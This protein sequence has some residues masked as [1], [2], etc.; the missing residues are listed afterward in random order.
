[1]KLA[2]RR[3]WRA[4][5]AGCLPLALLLPAVTGCLRIPAP[6][7]PE[8]PVALPEHWS[9]PAEVLAV[10]T[11][12][13]GERWWAELGSPELD[14]LIEEALAA[15]PSLP[16]AAARLEAASAR[17]R[18]AGAELSPQ[19]AAAL[20]ASR[21]RQ[22]FVGLPIPGAEDEVLTVLAT[23]FGAS[24]NL[25]W[26]ADLWGRLRAGR[27]AARAEVELAIE[28][29]RGARLSLAAQTAKAWL[30]TVEAVAQ[31]ALAEEVDASWQRTEELVEA[32]Y[33]RGLTDAVDLRLARSG[34][35]A[36]Q[37]LL[38]LR[39]RQLDAA[40]RQLEAILGRY[41]AAALEIASELPTPPQALPA[42]L[43]VE[44][45][46]RRPDLAAAERRLEAAG[47]RTRQARAAFFPQLR[48]TASG[49][50]LSREVGDLLDG[51]FA[52]WNLAAGILQPIFQGGRLRAGVELAE[53]GV[54]K[55]LATYALEILR[56]LTEVETALAAEVLLARRVAAL[57]RAAQ[58]A[59]AATES[60]EARYRAGLLPF[61]AV[62]EARRQADGVRSQLLEARRQAVTN[63]VDLYLALGG[64]VELP[65]GAS[66]LPAEGGPAPAMPILVP[67]PMP[68]PAMT[69]P[70]TPEPTAP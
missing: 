7:G 52:V 69:E 15:N 12:P 65:D 4:V 66:E 8:P 50:T 59:V 67:A 63:R 38:E 36:A 51:D 48:L 58:E 42:G 18:I 35:A 54:E 64:G 3:L 56:A 1:M 9:A 13:P 55:A 21:R 44:L 53:A 41:P 28:D 39:R 43:P 45:L 17:A 57:E 49:G 10:S 68:E 30:A 37:G 32:R 27:E 34:R 40:R 14:A 16:L 61:L 26:E 29:L 23:T 5:S 11:E 6:S 25:S 2:P 70:A 20:E 46:T 24:L 33:R 22:A 31:V 60:A 19:V 62:L 47:H